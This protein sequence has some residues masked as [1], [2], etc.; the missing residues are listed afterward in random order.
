MSR[1]GIVTSATAIRSP[2]YV[3]GMNSSTARPGV[4]MWWEKSFASKSLFS[5]AE[6]MATNSSGVAVTAAAAPERKRTV[7]SSPN[8]VI[9]MT[10]AFIAMSS[11]LWKAAGSRGFLSAA[12][13][14]REYFT[15]V[16]AFRLERTAF[17]DMRSI[18][19]SKTSRMNPVMVRTVMTK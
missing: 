15:A 9:R 17:W 7:P 6:L 19:F 10:P 16:P 4:S 11:I 12:I 14:S 8:T 3:K 5:I 18:W 1:I 13:A 2:A